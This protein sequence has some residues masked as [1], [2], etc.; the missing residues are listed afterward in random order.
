MSKTVLVVDDEEQNRKLLNAIL[1]RKGYNVLEA[2]NGEIALKLIQSSAVDIV[3]L[4]IIMPGMDGYEVCD[5]IKTNPNTKDIPV[6]IL[7]GK[8]MDEGLAGAAKKKANFYIVKPFDNNVLLA[9]IENMLKKK[10]G[11]V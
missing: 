5:R 7:T 9:Q 8:G 1:K 3:I 6:L 4:D 2:E 10:E 11:A